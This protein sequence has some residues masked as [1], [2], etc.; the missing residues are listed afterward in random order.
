M[1]QTDEEFAYSKIDRLAN[2]SGDIVVATRSDSGDRYA[3]AQ[4][5]DS[6]LDTKKEIESIYKP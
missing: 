6:I 1:R 5:T 3:N 2:D 4:V